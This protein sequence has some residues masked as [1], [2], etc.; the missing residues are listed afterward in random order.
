MSLSDYPNSDTE[1]FAQVAEI[2][3]SC[4]STFHDVLRDTQW[5]PATGS[6]ALQDVEALAQHDPG[7]PKGAETK[8]PRLLFFYLL[9][10]SEQLGG[11]AALYRACEVLLPPGPL[12]RNALEF[13]ARAS[14]VLRAPILEDRLARAYLEELRSSREA[15]K[16]GSTG[17]VR[18]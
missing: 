12:V 7:Y 18:L 2:F 13:C 11:V 16:P 1:R 3:A 8:I 17:V 4:R 15:A 9:A 14:W 6:A 10:A 5:Q